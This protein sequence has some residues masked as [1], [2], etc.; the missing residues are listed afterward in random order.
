VVGQ[1]LGPDARG[2]IR[3]FG[4]KEGDE[5]YFLWAL[6]RVA[7]VYGL[8]NVGEKDWYAWGADFLLSRQ[9]SDG[10]WHG[11]YSAGGVDSCFALLFLRKADLAKDLS[12]ILKSAGVGGEDLINRDRKP[13][14]KPTAKAPS[15]VRPKE[16]PTRPPT[17]KA[18]PDLDT[19]TNRLSGELVQASA[20]RQKELLDKF[21]QSKGVVYT[22]AL[23]A[24]IPQLSGAARTAARDALTERLARMTSATLRGRLQ[25]DNREIRQCAALA[26]IMKE[27][28]DR[29]PDLIPLLLD[30][31]PA[32]ARAAHFALRK[33]TD[34]DFGPPAQATDNQRTKAIADW[35][36]WWQRQKG[37]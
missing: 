26:C 10:G 27:D 1:P 18:D 37:K 6:E 28:R 33:L 32:V 24:A 30:S 16:P 22:Q 8:I 7:V 9:G 34:R 17:P 3:L 19:E 31:D 2:P 11:K 14:S 25:D 13:D 4:I 12:V 35:K 23:A 5:Y 21:A 36:A 29:V 15:L 20:S